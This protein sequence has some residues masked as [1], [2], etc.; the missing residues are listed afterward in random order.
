MGYKNNH[1]KDRSGIFLSEDHEAK[2]QLSDIYSARVINIFSDASMT[3]NVHPN[4][5]CKF[6][7]YGAIVVFLNEIIDKEYR[8]LSNV[9]TNQCELLGLKTALSFALKYCTRYDKINIFCD[10]LY[11]VDTMREYI[12]SYR[13]KYSEELGYNCL[14]N[15]QNKVIANQSAI[16]ECAELLNRVKFMNPNVTIY[17]TSGHVDETNYDSIKRAARKFKQ[18]NNVYET[19]DLN[20]IRYLSRY[21]NYIDGITRSYLYSIDMN[22]NYQIPIEFIPLHRY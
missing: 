1:I 11:T 17:H 6:G 14:Y 18:L 4:G 12:F 5:V 7:C 15:S 9:T 2:F 10:S 20:I 22:L 3:A 21:N 19:L 8:V 13:F 16:V